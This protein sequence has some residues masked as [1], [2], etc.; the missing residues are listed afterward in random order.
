MQHSIKTGLEYMDDEPFYESYYGHTLSKCEIHIV[1]PEIL[2]RNLDIY[3]TTFDGLLYVEYQ[4]K[5]LRKFLAGTDFDIIIVDTNSHVNQ[6]VSQKTRE[7]CMAEE[8]SYVKLPHS[9]FQDMGLF[10]DKLGVDMTWIW[11]NLVK[12][13]QPKYFGYLDQDCFLIKPI[14]GYLKNY[15]DEKGMYG[16]AFP[17][18]EDNFPKEYWL[19]H[20]MQNFFKYDFVKNIDLD[21]RPYGKLGLDTGG[22]N[23]LTLFKDHRRENYIQDEVLLSECLKSEFN[24]VFRDFTLHDQN[25]WVHIRNSTKVV[26]GHEKERELK[27]LYMKGFLNGVLVN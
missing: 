2:H 10:S 9:K 6:E 15:L 12:L 7:L 3:I 11:R 23:Y 4:I 16:R 14:W 27:E 19:V 17:S 22:C 20:I 5:T 21:F 13:R 1:E 24:E 26:S 8:V 25:R 18:N